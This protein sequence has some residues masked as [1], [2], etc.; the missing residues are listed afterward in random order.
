MYIVT[1]REKKTGNNFI[2]NIINLCFVYLYFVYNKNTLSVRDFNFFYPKYCSILVGFSL[3]STLCL[4]SSFNLVSSFV[5]IDDWLWL[6]LIM[7]C[8]FNLYLVFSM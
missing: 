3:A 4:I 5:N 8:V 2:V 7:T 1:T 6:M